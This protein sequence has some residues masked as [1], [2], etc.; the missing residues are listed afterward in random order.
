MTE[1]EAIDR[2][3]EDQCQNSE[4]NLIRSGETV[5]VEHGQDVMRHEIAAVRRAAF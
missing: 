3:V 4:L 2:D 5:R 1:H